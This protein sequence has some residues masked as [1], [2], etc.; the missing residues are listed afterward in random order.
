MNNLIK[1]I[2]ATQASFGIT[3]LRSGTSKKVRT[4]G[5]SCIKR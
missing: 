2:T 3:I 5:P 4:C 1:N